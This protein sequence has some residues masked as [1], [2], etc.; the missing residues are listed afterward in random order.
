MGFSIL[1]SPSSHSA[2]F[3]SLDLPDIY[4]AATTFVDENIERGR[5]GKVA[6]Y[7]QDRKITYQEVFENV[8]RTGNALR[9]LGIEIE[10][11]V[12]VIL[13]DSPEFAYCFFGAIKIGAVAVPTNPW[14]FAKDYEYLINDSRARAIIVHE[15]VLP[16]IE[17]TWDRMPF[18]KHILVVG[19]PK[20]KALS[21][22]NLIA[23]ASDK[24][25]AEKTTRDDVCFWGYTS[26]STGNPKGAV[27]LQHDMITI[28]DLFVKPVLGMTETDLCFS[29]SKMF[30]SYGLGNSLYFPFRF[31]ASTVLWP[32]KPE[33]EK[34][35]QVI[36]KYRPTFFFSVP[37]LFARFLRIEKKYDLSSLRVCLSSGEPLP[38]ALFHQ[39][40]DRT[41]LELLDVVGSTEATHDFLANRP[42]R[43]KA[44]SSG[45]VTPAFG[46]KIVDDDGKEVP[47]GEVGNLMVKG[48]AN[49]PYYWNKHEQTKRMM[50]GEWLKTGD[51][52]Y[53]DADGYYWY[54]GRSDDMMK[55]GGL[56]VSPIEIENALVEHPAVLESGVIGDSD[57]DGLL[58]PKAFV[59]L[60]SEFKPSA[61]LRQ[62]LQNHVK[63][64]LAPYKYPR[65]IEFVDDLPKTVTGKIQRFRLRSKN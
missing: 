43:A 12:L 22:E 11:R 42:G 7:Y 36:E 52:Y 28:T 4:N 31:G 20:A 54:C 46:A 41:G 14:M 16:E 39:W 21:Y 30:F 27:H 60:K 24:L 62:E 33:P 15:S 13:P 3:M 56:W 6:I 61:E 9:N 25:T 34:I 2:E 64:K 38:P 49:A 37:T 53:R 10:N 44:G 18:L 50:Q 58:K 48:D 35:L 17:K 40:K 23:N 5:G 63:S 8:N 1:Y 51:T 57:A 32:E 59:L 26:G 65:W 45:E 47:I 29:A 19:T 55:V